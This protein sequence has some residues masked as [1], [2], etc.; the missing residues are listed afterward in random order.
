ML[1]R[2]FLL[3]LLLM[4]CV[5]TLFFAPSPSLRH[6]QALSTSAND[7]ITITSQSYIIHFPNS[8]IFNVTASDANSTFVD[9]SITVNIHSNASI[10]LHPVAF[11]GSRRMLQLSYPQDISGNNFM[12]AGS[13]VSYSWHFT[14]KAG[15]IFTEPLQQFTL[16]DTRFTWQHLTRGL[17]QVNWYNRPLDFGQTIL[18]KASGDI[19]SIGNL[20]GG[21]LA[22]PI[23][24]W[25][26]Q[27]DVDFH[28][29]LPPG[30][31]EWVGGIAFPSLSEASIVVSGF[32]DQTLTRDMPHELTHLIFHQLIKN[33]ESSGVYA[34][35]W[36]DEG[37]A[38]YNQGYH[39]PDMQFRLNQALATHSLLHL[40][41]ISD[42]FPS[43]ADQA[44]LAYAQSWNLVGYMFKTFGQARMDALIK[45]MDNPQNDFGQDLTMA[46][47]LDEL[48]LENKWRLS[49]NQP[50]ILPA[51][52]LTPT[53]Q[54][55]PKPSLQVNSSGDDRSWV[56]IA[57]GGVL[58]VVSLGG[59]LA[60]FVA[61]NRRRRQAVLV[62]P[63][64]GGQPVSYQDPAIYM[65][66]S[67][68]SGPGPAS[69]P[70]A[71]PAG[72]YIEFQPPDQDQ[73]YPPPRRQYPQE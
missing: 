26:Y 46:L 57:L 41:D 52:Q 71:A 11:S 65:R 66:T 24:L 59:L 53:P 42:G 23:N 31:Y 4:F 10:E 72:E 58:V 36:F 37:L 62:T 56:L 47:G 48:H 3:V 34:P 60:L 27:T 9:A 20:L 73:S 49:L 21:G 15:N 40:I 45:D 17:L 69:P 7:A 67:M 61:T 51:D 32:F 70:P 18:D 35:T 19:Q 2:R 29:S 38:V 25:V 39:E 63:A 28:G 16:I 54:A 13:T 55:T 68:Y 22:D 14:D 30:T 44:Y 12:P 64:P 5:L 6:A 33:G 1:L 50:G 43:D 8:I